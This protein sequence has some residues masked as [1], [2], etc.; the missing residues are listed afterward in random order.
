MHPLA[1]RRNSPASPRIDRVTYPAPGRRARRLPRYTA[2]RS[3]DESGEGATSAATPALTSSNLIPGRP[4]G[5]TG[6][7]R[8]WAPTLDRNPRAGGA[9]RGLAGR[10]PVGLPPPEPLLVGRRLAAWFEHRSRT[11]RRA[12]CNGIAHRAEPPSAGEPEVPF[13]ADNPRFVARP[14]T[15]AAGRHAPFA[16]P[17]TRGCLD[18]R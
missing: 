10:L 6:V 11:C 5:S 14:V 1:W 3:E 18:R 15:L 17:V 13:T 9:G 8:R 16:N 12:C 7:P 4:R 2:T